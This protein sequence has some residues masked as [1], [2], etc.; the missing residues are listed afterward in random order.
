MFRFL[1]RAAVLSVVLAATILSMDLF[2][3]RQ[4]CVK[5]NEHRMMPSPLVGSPLTLVSADIR[6]INIFARVTPSI[7]VMWHRCLGDF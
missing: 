7:G 5:T 6:F 4:H 3:I 1:Q 2:I